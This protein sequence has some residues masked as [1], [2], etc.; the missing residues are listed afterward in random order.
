MS[1]VLPGIRDKIV[2]GEVYEWP[3]EKLEGKAEMQEY[4]ELIVW[5]TADDIKLSVPYTQICSGLTKIDMHY[6]FSL[7][8]ACSKECLFILET[9]W[10]PV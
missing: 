8:L 10:L 9:P 7:F 2:R 3:A 1:N 6:F 5:E 4:V